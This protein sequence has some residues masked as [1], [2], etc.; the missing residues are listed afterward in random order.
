MQA[1]G[2]FEFCFMFVQSDKCKLSNVKFT[3]PEEEEGIVQRLLLEQSRYNS[4]NIIM[5]Y[6]F[7][8]IVT[9]KKK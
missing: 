2:Y 9:A 6:L 4:R 8:L 1:S 7:T 3:N 5:Y